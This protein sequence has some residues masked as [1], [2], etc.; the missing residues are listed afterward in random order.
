M[1]KENFLL[2]ANGTIVSDKP[3]GIVHTN[4]SETIP[5]NL[6]TTDSTFDTISVESLRVSSGSGGGTMIFKL[7]ILDSDY[8][9]STYITTSILNNTSVSNKFYEKII[10]VPPNANKLYDNNTYDIGVTLSANGLVCGMI[11][12]TGDVEVEDVYANVRFTDNSDASDVSSVSAYIDTDHTVEVIARD[13]EDNNSN[14]IAWNSNQTYNYTITNS[15][16]GLDSFLVTNLNS[17]LYSSLG[18]THHASVDIGV[19][20]DGVALI[21]VRA[22]TY[23]SIPIGSIIRVAIV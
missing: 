15:L 22:S 13:D 6:D 1:G 12:T 10:T 8:S 2:A 19:I 21:K 4:W 5:Y 11:S 9:Q 7:Y 3:L 14:I 18:T 20:S 16:I 23:T 17:I